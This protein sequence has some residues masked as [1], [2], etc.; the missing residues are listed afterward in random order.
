MHYYTDYDESFRLGERIALGVLE[1]QKLTYN[2]NFSMT[3]P[4]FDGSSVRI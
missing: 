4:L 2:E 1:E 3:V